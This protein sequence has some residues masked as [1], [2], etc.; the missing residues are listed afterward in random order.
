LV[1]DLRNNPGGLLSQAVKVSDL[2]LDEGVIVS[3][4]GRNSAQNI[5]MNAHKNG[6]ERKYPIIVL[7]NGGSASA[8]EIVAGAMQDNK[9]ALILGTRTFG[10]GSVQTI[11][12]LGDGSGLRLTTARYYTPSGRSIQ[13]SGIVPDV[14]VEFIPP[15]EEKNSKKPHFLREED[16][17]GHMEND[18]AAKEKG[19]EKAREKDGKVED[20]LKKDNQVRYALQLLES[21]EI[22]SKIKVAQ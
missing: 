15:A 6:T 8:S 1:L 4:R 21:W 14:N 19:K 9:R 17:K 3:T 11:I 20:L 5:S 7:V 22:F 18:R 13:L 12:P 10:K 2:F 16:L